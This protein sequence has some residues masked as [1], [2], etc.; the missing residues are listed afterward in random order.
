MLFL[1]GWSGIASAEEKQPAEPENKPQILIVDE[2]HQALPKPG[3]QRQDRAPEIYQIEPDEAIGLDFTTYELKFQSGDRKF[4]LM[5]P[6][7]LD[8]VFDNGRQYKRIFSS[9]RQK[10]L[11]LSAKTLRPVGNSPSFP[12]FKAGQR[13]MMSLGYEFPRLATDEE[14]NVAPAWMGVVEVVPGSKPQKPSVS[15]EATPMGDF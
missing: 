8:V 14:G 4:N 10:R 1:L 7:R 2:A 3:P 13:F 15:K 11:E 6:N 5:K 9:K 12:G